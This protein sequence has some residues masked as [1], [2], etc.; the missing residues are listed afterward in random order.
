MHDQMLFQETVGPNLPL[1]VED[2]PTYFYCLFSEE[3]IDNLVFHTNFYAHQ[4]Q[5]PFESATSQSMKTFLA[6]HFLMGIKHLPSYRDWLAN[7][8]LRNEYISSLMPLNTFSWF[9][10]NLH[11]ADNNLQ[12]KKNHANYDK[13]Y[14]V[15]PLLDTLSKTFLH[16]YNPNKNQSIDESMIRFKERNSIKQYMPMKSIKRWYK[17]WTRADQSGYI[18]EFQIYIGKTDSIETFLGKRIVIELTQNIK[19]KYHCVYFDNFF[20]SLEL[21]E[22]LLQRDICMWYCTC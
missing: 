15:R 4:K 18:C 22:E 13:L 11:L 17:I 10:S 12:P 7:P 9:L 19:E 5:K 1:E 6:I 20:T 8:Q 21:M 16:H 2:P 14:K 3:F